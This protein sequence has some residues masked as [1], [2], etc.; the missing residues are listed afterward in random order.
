VPAAAE[1]YRLVNEGDAEVKVVCA[2]L[3]PE[4]FEKPEHDWLQPREVQ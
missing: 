3:K 1:S 2:S 4:W